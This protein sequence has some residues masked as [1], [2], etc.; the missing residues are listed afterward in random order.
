M[1]RLPFLMTAFFG[2][3]GSAPALAQ[4]D[5]DDRMAEDQTIAR[6]CWV[7][8]DAIGMRS[9]LKVYEVATRRDQSQIV[10]VGVLLSQWGAW[11]D[12]TYRWYFDGV[13][14]AAAA[15][16]DEFVRSN[17]NETLGLEPAEFAALKTTLDCG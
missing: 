2:L 1:P 17:V 15:F 8:A 9:T 10:G 3:A 13:T 5:F 16:D 14:S 12:V 11:Y 4:T 7:T 6:E